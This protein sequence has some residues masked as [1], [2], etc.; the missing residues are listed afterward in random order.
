MLTAL[1]VDDDQDMRLLLRLTIEMAN[2][3]L[4]VAGEA[5]SGSEA[6]AS[7]DIA[8]PGVVILDHRMPGMSGL[9]TAEAI[10]RDDPDQP[11][12]LFS[13]DLDAE[14]EDRAHALG[15]HLCLA[16]TEVERLPDALWQLAPGA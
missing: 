15:I 9:E 2:Q 13:A 10:L 5:S 7:I 1:I 12:I 3:G 14:T 6:L 4:S 16:K 8:R 11:I